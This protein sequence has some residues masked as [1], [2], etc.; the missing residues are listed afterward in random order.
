MSIYDDD[1]LTS[2]FK[3]QLGNRS[4]NTALNILED[5][6]DNKVG[7]QQ[8]RPSQVPVRNPSDLWSAMETGTFPAWYQ[9]E[10]T[11]N[12]G[13]LNAVGAGLW[14]GVDTLALNIPNYLL[15]AGGVDVEDYLD[16]DDPAAK[17]TGALGGFA[18]FVG[19]APMR[20]V[21]RGA[22]KLAM[23]TFGKQLLKKT[24]LET[25]DSINRIANKKALELGLSRDVRKN[26][27]KGYN[28]IVGESQINPNLWGKEF[29]FKVKNYLDEYIRGSNLSER[30][31]NGL[32]RLFSESNLYRRPIQDFVGVMTARAGA[33]KRMSRW[34]GHVAND[35]FIF[36]MI[37][38]VMETT[39]YLG[40]NTV[41]DGG[42]DFDWTQP[43][44][45]VANGA[46]FA[47]LGWLRPKGKS[48]V[49]KKDF[50]A[51]AR[52]AF[53]KDP[54]K[55]KT[56]EHMLSTAKFWG[57][58][59]KNMT[60]TVDQSTNEIVRGTANVK[61]RGKQFD[62]T[63]RFLEKD[64][65]KEFGK[66]GV[67]YLTEHLQS[68][69]KLFGREFIK[70]A[71]KEE[72]QSLAQVWKRMVMGGLLFNTQT[73]WH[74]YNSDAD[75]S[76]ASDIM[77]HF[78]IGA[79][80]Q[81][82]NNP[83]KVDLNSSKMNE[84]RQNLTLLG[85]S[86]E[87]F[88]R[89]PTFEGTG[90]NVNSIFNDT[91][92]KPVEDMMREEGIIT[93]NFETSESGLAEGA[94]S[95]VLKENP[96]FSLLYKNAKGVDIFLKP[97][98]DISV[99]TADRIAKKALEIEPRL[100]NPNER[101]RVTGESILK[102]T[103]KFEEE[104][105]SIVDFIFNEDVDKVTG[106]DIIT[107][108]DGA[109]EVYVP[110]HISLTDFKNKAERG[111]LKWLVDENNNVLSGDKALDEISNLSESLNAIFMTSRLLGQTI[112]NKI[113]KKFETSFKLDNEELL[114]KI[115]NKVK[116]SE[117]N[118]NNQFRSKSIGT[119]AFRFGR[120]M[121]DY[122]E[123]L[124][125]N[126][127]IRVAENTISI[128]KSDIDRETRDELK[129]HLR[130]S[131]LLYAG[132]EGIGEYMIVDSISNIKIQDSD[133]KTDS[134]AED[135]V[136]DAKRF[137]GRI[138]TLQSIV[139]AN[140]YK[141]YETSKR[142]KIH[143]KM[144]D[145][146]NL[147]TFFKNRGIDL[148][149][150]NDYMSSQLIDYAIR[151]KIKGTNLT[152][153]TVDT[154]FNLS[155]HEVEGLYL[156][157]FG[158][159]EKGMAGGFRVRKID[160]SFINPNSESYIIAQRYNNFIDK[161]EKD[162]AGLIAILDDTIKTNDSGFYQGIN[163]FFPRYDFEKTQASSALM[164]L[165]N[166]IQSSKYNLSSFVYQMELFSNAARG[167]NTM[168]LKWLADAK[169]LTYK[170]TNDFDIAVDK[171]VNKIKEKD[172]EQ[173]WS[174]ITKDISQKM[175]AHGYTAQYARRKYNEW[176]Q[177]ARDF[178][179][180]DVDESEYNKNITLTEFYTKYR[181]DGYKIDISNTESLNEN[182]N[183]LL[184][185]P[186]GNLK[187]KKDVLDNIFDRI[188]IRRGNTFLSYKELDD[189]S[190]SQAGEEIIRDVVGL[191]AQY[192]SQFGIN[193]VKWV[194][195]KVKNSREVMQRS[196][197]SD[198]Y[199]QDLKL[200]YSLV[201]TRAVIYELSDDGRRIN[202]VNINI[203]GD[204]D[205]LSVDIREKIQSSRDMFEK[206][207]GNKIY[208]E[209]DILNTG[210]DG[211]MGTVIMR[212]SPNLEPISISYNELSNISDA[213]KEFNNRVKLYEGVS[214]KIIENINEISDGFTAETP[215]DNYNY[216]LTV[217]SMEKMLTGSDGNKFFVDWINGKNTAKTMGRIKIFNSKKFLRADKEFMK[218]VQSRYNTL[219]NLANKA[220]IG[221][222]SEE[223]SSSLDKYI[224]Q[225]G[226]NLVIWDDGLN[227]NLRK[228]T[229][230]LIKEAGI[231]NINLND[232]IGNAHEK[233]TSFDSIA[234]VS[235]DMLRAQKAIIGHDPNS[236]TPIK[237]VISSQGEDSPLVLGKT[238]FV[239]NN[240]LDEFFN[241]EGVD[242]LL[243]ESGAKA[244]NP[245][246][247][248][249]TEVSLFRTKDS[250]F[251][252]ISKTKVTKDHIR[253]ISLDS[254]GLKA[255]KDYYIN[256][257]K[258]AASDHNYKNNRESSDAYRDFYAEH[259]NKGIEAI[260]TMMSDPIALRKWVLLE[261]GVDDNMMSTIAQS[262]GMSHINNMVF[263][264]NL[265][266]DMDPMTYSDG[267][268]K[269]KLYNMYIGS[270]INNMR[271]VV[272]KSNRRGDDEN[273]RYGGQSILIQTGDRLNPTV[274]DKKGDML[275]RGEVMLSSR[276]YNAPVEILDG[277]NNKKN[278]KL[279]VRFVISGVKMTKEQM[280]KE[281][282]GF[283]RGEDIFPENVWKN[284]QRQSGD[285]ILRLGHLH[286]IIELLKEEGNLPQGLRI[287]I[288]V[289]RQPR[290]RP[291]D[292]SVLGLKGFLDD[293]FGNSMQIN[294]FDVANIYE[295][296][297][298]VDKADYWFSQKDSFY[299]HIERA[300]QF[301][302]QGVD[303]T[304]YIS[305]R[306]IDF[307]NMSVTEI[308]KTINTI[309]ADN[310]LFKSSIGIVQTI[311]RK[312]GYIE[313]LGVR[314][315]K[316]DDTL[317]AFE[318]DNPDASFDNARLL[319]GGSG[320]NKNF[321]IYVD[322]DNNDFF[323]RAALETQY[324][325]DAK[326][327]INEN[328]SKDIFSWANDF[329]FPRK[330]E[331]F[332][333]NVARNQNDINLIND[334]RARGNSRNK[335]IRI[336]RKLEYDE[337][338]KVWTEKNLNDLEIAA[339]KEMLNE[340]G[341]LLN[342]TG[343][344]MYENSGMKKKSSFEDINDA[345]EN[346]KNFNKNINNSLYYR[347]R[348]KFQP[349]TKYRWRDE[350][351]PGGKIFKKLFG[352][353]SGEYK[354]DAGETKKYYKPTMNFVN[355]DVNKNGV[356]FTT[357]QRGAP[358]DRILMNLNISDVFKRNRRVDITGNMASMIDDWYFEVESGP[359]IQD[360]E[361][362]TAL[363]AQNVATANY[364]LTKTVN[365]IKNL[366]YK[367]SQINN[368][369]KISFGVKKKSIDK[370]NNFIKEQEKRISSMI[371][372]KYWKTKKSK[373]LKKMSIVAITDEDIKKSTIYYNVLNN[374]R[375]HLPGVGDDDSFGLSKSGIAEL[376]T[377][378][379]IRKS[380]YG[381]RT[382]LKQI[383]E[384][385]K[386]YTFNISEENRKLLKNFDSDL[387]TI[388][389]IENQLLLDG[390]NKYGMRFLYAFMNPGKDKYSIGVFENRPQPIPFKNTKRYQRGI[391]FLTG[392]A[393]GTIQ[394]SDNNRIYA[395]QIL[396][397]TGLL[398][399][400]WQR[401]YNNKVDMRKMY[402]ENS[403]TDDEA[404]WVFKYMKMPKFDK[405]FTKMFSRYEGLRFYAD[406]DR[407]G[408][409]N[410]L[411]N[412]S[413]ISFYRDIMKVAGKELEF[414]SY[415]T[416]MNEIQERLINMEIIDPVEYL[417]MRSQMDNEV[418]EIAKNVFNSGVIYEKG[419]TKTVQNIL[420][421]PVFALIG[422]ENY[423]RGTTIEKRN[424][425][426]FERLKH[427]SDISKNSENIKNNII[428]KSSDAKQKFEEIKNQCLT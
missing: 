249:G 64:L 68:Q 75:I 289:R 193:V 247:I 361:A 206:I 263:Y 352:V 20:I 338:N 300:S 140:D 239:Y 207:M 98:E 265:S 418:M 219:N 404:N 73:F 212:V 44:W 78:L 389:D 322:F 71:T 357:A 332:T 279:N 18:G 167:N 424:T 286:D 269:N 330:E 285:G 94:Q 256:T 397:T 130:A 185:T 227:A 407:I 8:Q 319:F 406:S 57:N 108:T 241:R 16:F 90:L 194:D 257:A 80:M 95:V 374:I 27:L 149:S 182:L 311:P 150:M 392:I 217:L 324:L 425:K 96:V 215:V 32:N 38:T 295:G 299:D 93:D 387:S 151:D 359:S 33:D 277:E 312:L 30:Q 112:T 126:H 356:E 221:S 304:Q 65:E 234:F 105:P 133:G 373:D 189:I 77:P 1:A 24:G 60:R 23:A 195:G 178:M 393:N 197:L 281:Q 348:N 123:I 170:K 152:I 34:L 346:F 17:W 201:D 204:T 132:K 52:A 368:N 129:R 103:E 174:D 245:K 342:I 349:G 225:D 259:V 270:L 180:E 354:D 6:S 274:V 258:E 366:K 288:A 141:T 398:E 253:K 147:K 341:S 370:I 110:Q 291:N 4:I 138:L 347:L 37:D 408:A 290:T 235:R 2:R 35:V 121:D 308:I 394:A 423:F 137:L 254:V 362:A 426:S 238:L 340:Y 173:P 157:R 45:G 181:I 101:R 165:F 360:V 100:I 276:D 262:E 251:D 19:G 428:K 120:N 297:Y 415:L 109:R 106:V 92:Y 9:D 331:S 365:L 367:I 26:V 244:Y 82:R 86:P 264:S 326:G 84:L 81:R 233:A 232:T 28:R 237:P 411:L 31:I 315:D 405:S 385:S 87:Q 59:L 229:E 223:I 54:Y 148:D 99:E 386:D 390:I 325:I 200:N 74:M 85:V 379:N 12:A 187:L 230:E 88:S 49:W 283:M 307:K 414:E 226:Y 273:Q 246:F 271:S 395:E 135:K 15:K 118:I 250:T 213:F 309:S 162:S 196:K 116:E 293:E 380:F 172:E 388:Y 176:E 113:P 89:I 142:E 298:D 328:I 97:M 421:N 333:P 128:F 381:N 255:D 228:E 76:V 53:G 155:H 124:A 3:Q 275:M 302:V 161:A 375:Y 294:S 382:T 317:K 350:N 222:F 272:N 91:K 119:D 70:W 186:D 403:Y 306:P 134:I 266:R 337:I 351:T 58:Q 260:K 177:K 209:G 188:F 183:T 163:S 66:K 83:A 41:G 305:E 171:L 369:E 203:F 72:A 327:K 409:N 353:V 336:F 169:V 231:D 191:V 355:E 145:V 179:W 252:S 410:K 168:L 218:N 190:K 412:D 63:S 144:E 329:L 117:M 413:T 10:P 358:V 48:T 13:F 314:V 111:E 156:T 67:K 400:Q 175:D 224:K 280:T 131:G 127:T 301:F 334:M 339:I 383:F 107:N 287:A 211:E 125:T 158:T 216:A 159:K 205:N 401:Y 310:E 199:R 102:T 402:D 320:E 278:K 114:S 115:Y 344:H 192:K 345:T 61:I 248:E 391:K 36:S 56:T 240:K 343:S 316:N 42:Y 29:K 220:G 335:R 7:P 284:I 282:R 5:I 396:K 166:S 198:F 40:E 243:T 371:P 422:G 69:R 143:I 164:D 50:I 79:W 303:P 417:S 14:Q 323:T 122:V 296:D 62:L 214:E 427:I 146:D 267:L 313:K 39:R 160:L 377:L 208:S 11:P 202:R 104:F 46:A 372:K 210:V 378:K 419:K 136:S 236:F 363:L 376:N 25:A 21:G 384:Y 268:V 364:G 416:Q 47:S 292:M 51:G 321:K 43:I 261:S 399:S 22:Q 153:D 318:K 184:Y 154:L 242:I 139:G 420:N 55:N